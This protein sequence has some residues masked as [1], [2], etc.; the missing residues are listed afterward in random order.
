LSESLDVEISIVNT[1]NRA[2][3]ERCLASL[4]NACEG[5][6]WRV[7]VVDNAST[8]DSESMLRAQFPWAG[9]LKNER[10]LGFSASHN[11]VLHPAVA[12][13]ASRYVMILN[14]D[15]ELEPGAIRKLVDVADSDGKL[16][17]IGPRI[18]RPD[19]SI[20]PS[21]FRFPTL[22]REIRRTIRPGEPSPYQGERGWLNGSCILLRAAALRTVG[23]LDERFFIFYEDTD[24][25]LR[26]LTSGWTSKV[27]AQAKMLHLEHRTV[28][29]P[30]IHEDMERQMLRS[31]VQYFEKHHGRVSASTLAFVSRTALGLRAVRAGLRSLGDEKQRPRAGMLFRL[32][33]YDPH[34]P[35]PHEAATGEPGPAPTPSGGVSGP[36]AGE[37]PSDL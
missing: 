31:R 19:G 9:V 4:P 14:E 25:C 6:R 7:A 1:N 10:R 8:D 3:L 33:R 20:Q 34:D 23:G 11:R 26:L 17:A 5:L 35:L 13:N 15:T 2:L 29:D 12:G 30:A 18:H 27:A 36:R 16:A 24:L 28:G 22:W 37:A 21:W 32:A